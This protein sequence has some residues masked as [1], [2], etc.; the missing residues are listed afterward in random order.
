MFSQVGAEYL[1]I[2]VLPNRLCGSISQ[3]TEKRKGLGYIRA[4]DLIGKKYRVSMDSASRKN[5]VRKLKFLLW[6]ACPVLEVG[7]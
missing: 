4:L 5:V 1:S 6:V 7:S 3:K 2:S